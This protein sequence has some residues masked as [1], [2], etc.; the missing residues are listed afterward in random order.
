MAETEISKLELYSLVAHGDHP[1]QEHQGILV[2]LLS[3]YSHPLPA[4]QAH[5]LLQ[6]GP[7]QH[8]TVMVMKYNCSMRSHNYDIFDASKIMLYICICNIS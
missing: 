8:S 5:H 7:E 2:D 4:S 6:G 1:T 3:H